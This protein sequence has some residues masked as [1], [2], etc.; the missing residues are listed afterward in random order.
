MLG[1]HHPLTA[2]RCRLYLIGWE[3]SEGSG[4]GTGPPSVLVGVGV[5]HMRALE[6]VH[7]AVV[8]SR[9]LVV[10][11]G[12]I[13][14]GVGGQSRQRW[15]QSCHVLHIKCCHSSTLS[16]STFGTPL[17]CCC[18]RQRAADD[19][20]GAVREKIMA[21]VQLLMSDN[22]LYLHIRHSRV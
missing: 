17:S 5:T 20:A 1:G 22:I 7:L 9:L 14:A 13:G 15:L 11:Q 18:T 6:R 3:E 21:D 2:S 16:S 12:L 19:A 10:Q 8:G 4:P